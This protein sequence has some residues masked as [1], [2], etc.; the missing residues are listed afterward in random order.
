MKQT[1]LMEAQVQA[2]RIYNALGEVAD[3][4][5]QIAEALDRNDSVAVQ[6]LLAMREEPLLAAHHARDVLRQL[7]NDTEDA[8]R[9]R[10][11]LG[12]AAAENAEESGLAN[13]IAI[14]KR[15]LKQVQ[16]LDRVLSQ[17]IAREKS[18]YETK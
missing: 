15:L 3:L 16:D 18:V 13:Q 5:A 17:K 9:L 7:V 4:S 12:G 14:N 2:R 1:N 11:L 10:A 6:I 8:T